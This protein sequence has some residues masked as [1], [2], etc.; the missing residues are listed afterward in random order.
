[1][2]VLRGSVVRDRRDGVPGWLR[3]CAAVSGQPRAPRH[4]LQVTL[5]DPKPHS[6]RC[7]GSLGRYQQRCTAVAYVSSTSIMR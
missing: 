3:V 1:M 7:L 5:A 4:L 6:V 2:L